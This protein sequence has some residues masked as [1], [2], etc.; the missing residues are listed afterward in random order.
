MTNTEKFVCINPQGV[1]GVYG[2]GETV[3]EAKANVKANHGKLDR[4]LVWEM[5]DGATEVG[6]DMMG[7]LTWMWAEGADRNAEPKIVAKRAVTT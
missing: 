4:Y 7:R 5:P 1:R 6:V 2:K 3:A